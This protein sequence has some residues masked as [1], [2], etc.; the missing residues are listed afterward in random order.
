MAL[1]TQEQRSVLT[2]CLM[3]AFADGAKHDRERDQIK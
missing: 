2:I 1:E 3:A